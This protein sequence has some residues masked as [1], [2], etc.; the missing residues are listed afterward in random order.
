MEQ[1]HACVCGRT[2]EG[3]VHTEDLLFQIFSF[4]LVG[5]TTREKISE[6]R[7]RL[8]DVLLTRLFPC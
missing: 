6:D 1:E 3:R 7:G 8:T 4:L 2:G 5:K